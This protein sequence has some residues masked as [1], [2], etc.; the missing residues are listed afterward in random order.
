MHFKGL[1]FIFCV[2]LG[3]MLWLTSPLFL[4]ENYREVA[5]WLPL[6]VMAQA[7]VDVSQSPYIGQDNQEEN[8][9]TNQNEENQVFQPSP[10]MLNGDVL[11]EIKAAIGDVPPATRARDTTNK[12][13][14]IAQDNS[15][16]LDNI[17]VFKVESLRVISVEGFLINVVTPEDAKLAN[18]STDELVAQRLQAI[19]SG[20]Q[21]YRA[22]RFP[23]AIVN[24]LIRAVIATAFFVLFLYLLNRLLPS[25]F[26]R[27][28]NWQSQRIERL[29][30]QGKGIISRQKIAQILKILYRIIRVGSNLLLLYIYI[31]LILSCFPPTQPVSRQIVNY[32]WGA[33][34]LVWDGLVDYLPNLFII[35]LI[36]VIAF[37]SIR[38]SH[39]I[40]NEIRRRRIEIKGF[41]PEWANPTH[42]IVVFLIVGL[43]LVFVYPYLPAANSTGFQGVSVF[44]G[45]LVTFGS[46]AIIGNI[47]SGI[48]LIYTRSFQVGDVIRVNNN[49]GRV[50]EKTML[51]TRIITPDNE[52]ITLPNASLF[53]TEITNFT[54]SIRDEK[55]PLLLKTTI[56]L[57]Y[58]VPWRKVHETLV[59][60]ASESEGILKDPEPFV[61][62]TSLDD[63]YVAYTLKAYTN[64]PYKMQVVYSNLHQNIQD[65]CNEVDIEILSP[66]YRAVRDGNMTTIPSD[67]LPD[68]YQAPGFRIDGTKKL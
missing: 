66:H 28:E 59:K 45:A 13:L 32:F 16:S 57:G 23:E 58:D 26:H 37:Y 34:L 65:K 10:V 56:T 31:P 39:F 29:T 1:R 44:I 64:Q 18:Q 50:L 60:A 2:I 5:N 30:E 43:A 20:I 61:V 21:E 48:V 3:G 17:E 4:N 27:F 46:T 35:T 55:K 54:A 67:Y 33:V 40:F 63:F 42:N 12:I 15:L 24:G 38:F 6:Q 19:K 22:M 25:F 51:S 11:F 8:S 68:D 62:Q 14:K 9:A 47:V 41:Y 36:L 7:Q 53:G 52:I 49:L